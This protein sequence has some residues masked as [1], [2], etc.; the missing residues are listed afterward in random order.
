MCIVLRWRSF[1][2]TPC[3][4]GGLD[5]AE[6][7]DTILSLLLLWSRICCVWVA[8]TFISTCLSVLT[9]V[10]VTQWIDKRKQVRQVSPTDDTEALCEETGKKK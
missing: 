6:G 4:C 2:G 7:D 5:K 9:R 3:D 8:S 1:A 10:S